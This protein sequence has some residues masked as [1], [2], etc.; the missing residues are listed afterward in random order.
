MG[1]SDRGKMKWQGAF[2]MPEHVK[3]LGDLQKDYYCTDK[4]QLDSYQYDEFD[5]RIGEAVANNLQLTVTVW[6]N[7]ISTNIMGRVRDMDPLKKQLQIEGMP[8]EFNRIRFEDIINVV[9]NE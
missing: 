7:G 3:M 8:G 9:V 5:E 1:I 2:F 6:E 4:P